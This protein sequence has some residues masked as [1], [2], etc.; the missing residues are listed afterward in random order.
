MTSP[1][2]IV[3]P[4]SLAPPSGFSHAVVT[5]A[6]RTVWLGGQTA[7]DSSG[8][9]QGEGVVE[10]FDAAASNVVV[11]LDAAGA[12][13]EHLVSMQIFVTDANEYRGSLSE[14]GRVYRK[15]FGSHY[16]ATFLFEIKGLFDPAE[17]VEILCVAVVPTDHR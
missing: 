5:G 1:H 12:R 6:G 8:T 10:Q 16:P 11:A 7:H 15:H 17:K 2:E 14:L 9:I 3:N 4:D 13:P